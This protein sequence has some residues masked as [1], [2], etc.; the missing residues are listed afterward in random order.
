MS[1]V[2]ININVNGQPEQKEPQRKAKALRYGDRIQGPAVFMDGTLFRV[3]GND[4]ISLGYRP[5]S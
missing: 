1:N 3:D 2:T 4:L 5:A